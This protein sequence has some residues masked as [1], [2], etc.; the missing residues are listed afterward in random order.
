MWMRSRPLTS[1]VAKFLRKSC[2]VKRRSRKPGCS[3]PSASQR[4]RIILRTVLVPIAALDAGES[5]G[6]ER[7]LSSCCS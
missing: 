7:C 5:C 6:K 1:S 4:H 3:S 2:G